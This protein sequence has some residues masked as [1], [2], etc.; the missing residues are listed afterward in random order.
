M[1]NIWYFRYSKKKSARCVHFAVILFSKLKTVTIRS[2]HHSPPWAQR[3]KVTASLAELIPMN[4][5]PDGVGLKCSVASCEMLAPRRKMHSCTTESLLWNQWLRLYHKTNK[6][7]LGSTLI[8]I[9]TVRV[10]SYHSTK[11]IRSFKHL[12]V[13]FFILFF[14]S[15]HFHLFYFIAF[16]SYFIQ[17]CRRKVNSLVVFEDRYLK[18]ASGHTKRKSV[19]IEKTQLMRRLINCVHHALLR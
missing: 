18:R 10:I 7:L 19:R 6:Y 9:S 12:L 8:E 17:V 4:S 16:T 2:K 1:S 5:C 11:L 14:I 13:K 3:I 15:F